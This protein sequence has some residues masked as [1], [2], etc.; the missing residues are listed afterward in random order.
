[1]EDKIIL[2]KKRGEY[3]KKVF[4]ILIKSEIIDK[5]DKISGKSG[6]SRNEIIAQ[7][8]SY[9]VDHIEIE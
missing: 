7:I 1:M 4:S 6:I 8:L 5:L 2:I 3:D 9:G